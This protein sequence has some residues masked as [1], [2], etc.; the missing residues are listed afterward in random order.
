MLVVSRRPGQSLLV[1]TDIEV[2]VVEVKNNQVRIGINAPRRIRVLRRELM[3]QVE[4]ENR[5][6]AETARPTPEALQ[7]LGSEVRSATNG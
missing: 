6:A 7:G 3:T 1:G 5:R 4:A 2:F